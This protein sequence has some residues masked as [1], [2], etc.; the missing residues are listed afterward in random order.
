MPGPPRGR[1]WTTDGYGFTWPGAPAGQP[2]NYQ[3]AGQTVPVS[4]PPGTA[5][6]GVLGAAANAGAAGASGAATNYSDGTTTT[7]TLSMPDWAL[8]GSAGYA[9]PGGS[10]EALVLADRNPR[11]SGPAYGVYVFATT[12]ALNPAKTLVSVTL[13]SS[14]SGGQL[15]V[16]AFQG[17][18]GPG[19]YDHHDGGAHHDHDGGAHDH[20]GAHH[21]HHGA[22]RPRL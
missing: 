7:F 19:A 5:A 20:H 16:F 11:R 15:H 21:H 13:P 22:G 1:C 2:D 14:S 18:L 10:S 17:P 3:A 4:V 12:V 6:L 8:G 9:V